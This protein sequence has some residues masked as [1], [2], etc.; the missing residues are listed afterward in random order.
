[1]DD[2]LPAHLEAAALIR[3]VEADGGFAAILRKGDRDRGALILLIRS[4]GQVVGILERRL[5]A[6]FRYRWSLEEQGSQAAQDD[7][8]LD[9]RLRSD[10]DCWLIELDIAQP[11]RFIA[12]TIAGG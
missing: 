2:R 8:R 12:E 4:R 11:E 9:S 1:M 7:A 3:Q 6:D 10:P 5:A